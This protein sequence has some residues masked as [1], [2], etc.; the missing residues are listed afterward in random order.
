LVFRSIENGVA[1]VKA[2]QRYDSAVI[3]PHGRIVAEVVDP[4]GRQALVV[5]DVPLGTGRR[6]FWNRHAGHLE[7]LWLAAALAVATLIVHD[8]RAL[9]ARRRPEAPVAP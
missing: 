6:T 3:D 2:D 9:R 1:T 4:G 7:L 5:A 8:L